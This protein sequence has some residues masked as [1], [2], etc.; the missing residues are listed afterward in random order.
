MKRPGL[1]LIASVLVFSPR[2][3][4]QNQ[5][6]PTYV[7]TTLTDRNNS[8][9]KVDDCSLREAIRAATAANVPAMIT[10][11]EGLKGTLL[12]NASFGQLT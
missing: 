6:G 3:S 8:T 5:T 10:F 9:A 11:K 4:A 7:V 12:L 1:V 2:L